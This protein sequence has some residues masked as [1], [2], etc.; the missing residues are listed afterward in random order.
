MMAT[1]EQLAHKADLQPFATLAQ[2][3]TAVGK[4]LLGL[5]MSTKTD[6]VEKL[7]TLSQ[8]E[9]ER[10]AELVKTLAEADPKQKAQMLRIRALR[11]NS[12]AGR[13][14]GVSAA[15]SDEK[16]QA[17]AML[18]AK[19]LATK[20]TAEVASKAFKDSP[21]QLVGTGDKDWRL[22][23]EAA[24]TFAK[25]S[26][27]GAEFPHLGPEAQC[28]LCQ[29]KL[30]DDG[31]ARLAAFDAFIE[32]AAQQAAKVAKE[33]AVA[34]YRAIEQCSV[35]LAI[36]EALEKELSD[37]SPDL[38]VMCAAMQKSLAA[39]H[40][41]IL[42]A[43]VPDGDWTAVPAFSADPG[44]VL[45][46]QKTKMEAAAKALEDTADPKA[47]LKMIVERDELE[48]RRRLGEIKESVLNA[49]AKLAMHKKLQDCVSAASSTAGISRKA[50]ELAR[51]MA[52]PEV[53]TALNAELQALNVH[54]LRI[55]MKNESP[56][57]KT[58][59]KLALELTGGE[60][61]SA[62]LSE[63]EQRAISIASFLAEVNLG[64]GRGGV[65][66]DDPVSSL[67]H[68]RRWLVAER[69]AREASR[70]QVIVFT[71]DIYFLCIL[72]QHA[73]E[74]GVD[75]LAQCIRKDIG[76]FGVQ[77]NRLPFEALK[78]TKRVSA[79]RQMQTAVEKA[80]KEGADD[81][82]KRLTREAYYHLRLA[83]ER[84]VEE[85]LFQGV[86][87]RFEEGI[88][89]KMLRYV[90]VEDSDNEAINSGM[91][92]CSK[93]E[94]DG[95]ARAQVPTPTPAELKVDIEALETWRASVEARK[96]SVEARRKGSPKPPPS[97]NQ[98]ASSTI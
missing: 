73:S 3:Q 20:H 28:P 92:R 64:P 74:A 57:G 66:F 67:D 78:T 45:F 89:T 26:H 62:I 42:K 15:I 70:R 35:D 72:Q 85:V 36:D 94:H 7:A 86:V 80:Q 33:E 19:R 50:T 18:I 98:S 16:M 11:L 39:R 95:A 76:G 31:Q 69:L 87:S 4:L 63:G 25:T 37:T 56:Q 79:L 88:A 24:R 61:P 5:P 90:V 30:G 51:T 53:V 8:A 52:T 91:T 55:V 29:N 81:E 32:A 54:E 10:L 12:L 43:A 47:K 46:E 82:R 40:A 68:V 75:V 38:A 13:V 58:Q 77:T 22:L 59:F 34:A 21:G 1:Q 41:A 97:T 14:A 60:K 6:D 83:W 96:Q 23:I 27:P 48:A 2:A 17:L 49:I 44:P 93:F 71:H 9:I 65:V 84:S